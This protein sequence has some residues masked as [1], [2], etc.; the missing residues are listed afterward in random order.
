MQLKVDKEFD[1]LVE[2]GRAKVQ[3]SEFLKDEIDFCGHGIDLRTA[4]NQRKGVGSFKCFS[5]KKRCIAKQKAFLRLVTADDS[6]KICYPILLH[7]ITS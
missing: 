4:Q 5:A 3:K 7:C 6:W 1:R 2:A